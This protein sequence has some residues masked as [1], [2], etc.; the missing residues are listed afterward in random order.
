M[1]PVRGYSPSGRSS[2][3]E[4]PDVVNSDAGTVGR[5]TGI[6][7]HVPLMGRLRAQVL[8]CVRQQRDVTCALERG[9]QHPLVTSARAGLAA[10]LDLGALAEI[11]AEA[12]HLLVVDALGLV[13]AEVADLAATSIAVVVRRFAAGSWACHL[14][15]VPR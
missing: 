8:G 10:R 9:G 14:V 11:A 13:D 6:D 15:S 5:S 12:V 3:A 4:R 2:V 7:R 1:A